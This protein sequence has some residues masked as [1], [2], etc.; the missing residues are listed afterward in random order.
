MMK[1]QEH[2]ACEERL[3]ELR[4]FSLEKARL[5]RVLINAYKYLKGRYK[6]EG[7]RLFSMMP[8]DSTRH[9]GQKL[10]HVRCCLNIR[11]H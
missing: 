9:N 5:R 7:A 6:E 1:G 3:R 10:K 11:K 8:S 4:L 2:L